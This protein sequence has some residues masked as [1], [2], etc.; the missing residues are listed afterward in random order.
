M[1]I[2]SL[3]VYVAGPMTG[4]ADWN[5]PEFRR[6]TDRLRGSGFRVTNP[7]ELFTHTDQPWEFYMKHAL[8]A[9]LDCDMIFLLNGWSSSRG[10]Q[11]ELDLAKKVGMGVMFEVDFF[12][13][14]DRSN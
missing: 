6:N 13:E 9:M 7:A 4:I 10:A 3:K 5:K 12:P 1:S 11:I 2:N 8:K 14:L